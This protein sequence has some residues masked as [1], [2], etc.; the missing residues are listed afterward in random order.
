MLTL[1]I[2]TT[3]KINKYNLMSKCFL[4]NKSSSCSLAEINLQRSQA[5]S[6]NMDQVG[7]QRM[8]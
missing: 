8:R 1:G 6:V 2:K 4:N 5:E 3:V 7:V